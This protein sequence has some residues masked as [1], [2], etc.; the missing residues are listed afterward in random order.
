[1]KGGNVL[2]HSVRV[3]IQYLSSEE[4]HPF[5]LHFHTFLPCLS[6]HTYGKQPAPVK[7]Y[8]LITLPS[9]SISR[10]WKAHTLCFVGRLAL[11]LKLLEEAATKNSQRERGRERGIMIL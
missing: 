4:L 5:A 10:D 3:V 1:M 9:L 6:H 7:T 8:E 2:K 11:H